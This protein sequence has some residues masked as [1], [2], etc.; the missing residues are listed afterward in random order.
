MFQSKIQRPAFAVAIILAAS[1][2]PAVSA[3]A[4]TKP[5][6]VAK[7]LPDPAHRAIF[8]GID[9]G[10][11]SRAYSEAVSKA[12]TGLIEGGGAR[13]AAQA[14]EQLKGV[15][16]KPAPAAAPQTPAKQAAAG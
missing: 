7:L 15:L 8:C 1:L 5:A 10:E 4:Q 14:I 2:L 11:G 9:G 12:I 13:T 16:C 3:Q 6:D